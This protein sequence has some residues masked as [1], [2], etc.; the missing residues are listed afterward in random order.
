[1]SYSTIKALRDILINDANLIAVVPSSSILVGWARIPES[2]PCIVIHQVGGSDVG[3]LGYGTAPAGSKIREERSIFQINIFSDKSR[4]Q[5][6]EIADLIRNALMSS[7]YNFTKGADVD[8]WED[9]IKA[10]RKAVTWSVLQYVE[11]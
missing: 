4:K 7:E 2:Y 3:H 5:T 8:I 11:D 10:Y 6:Y 9:E 1:M